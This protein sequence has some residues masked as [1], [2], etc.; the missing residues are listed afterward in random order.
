ML[1][2]QM[3]PDGQDKPRRKKLVLKKQNTRRWGRE[4]RASIKGSTQKPA[5]K[6]LDEKN[7]QPLL[8]GTLFWLRHILAGAKDILNIS[9]L[10]Y[11]MT[12]VSRSSSSPCQQIHSP[13]WRA[14]NQH[15]INHETAR[16]L[17]RNV[18]FRNKKHPS[19]SKNLPSFYRTLDVILFNVMKHRLVGGFNP[20][21]K[22]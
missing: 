6:V 12:N 17:A 2:T 19:N 5:C 8:H 21:E 14:R 13:G 15:L 20:F 1:N 3:C 9:K 4:S 11:C 18:I 7:G 16:C 10:W 22:Y